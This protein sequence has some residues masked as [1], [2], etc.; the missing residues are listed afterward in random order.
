MRDFLL[1][2]RTGSGFF[3]KNDQLLPDCSDCTP[4]ARRPTSHGSLS[5]PSGQL[6]ELV[7]EAGQAIH[8]P[9][10]VGNELRYEVLELQRCHCTIDLLIHLAR[11]FAEMDNGAATL[12]IQTLHGV[13]HLLDL[14]L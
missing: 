14:L 13:Q 2:N 5:N 10:H 8:P 6:R 11:V 4:Q 12:L 7:H 3:V 1:T 9:I